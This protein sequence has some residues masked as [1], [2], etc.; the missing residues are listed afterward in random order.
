MKNKWILSVVSAGVMLAG[1]SVIASAAAT[2]TTP[3]SQTSTAPATITVVGSADENVRPDSAVVSAGVS[4]QGKTAVK[5]EQL[6]NQEMNRLM[7]ALKQ[8]QIPAS[9]I[10]TQWFNLSPDY[11]K[12]STNGQQ[13]VVGFTTTNTISVTVKNLAKVGE[14][15]DLLVKSGA[16]QINNVNYMVTN[17]SKIQQS[18][19]SLALDNARKQAQ[20][21]AG[22]LGVTITGVQSVDATQQSGVILPIFATAKSSQAASA[23]LSPGTQDISAS[24]TVVYTIN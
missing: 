9:D 4:S 17:P 21:I 14:I 10:Q 13:P 20:S 5:A 2:K 16:N 22:K 19:Y 1:V 12:P 11:G 6:N 3:A 24:L 23:V 8:D 18:L 15:V 7:T